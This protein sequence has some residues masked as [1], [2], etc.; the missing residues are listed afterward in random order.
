[1]K[2]LNQQQFQNSS[3]RSYQIVPN[4]IKFSPEIQVYGKKLHC[5]IRSSLALTVFFETLFT[6]GLIL[7]KQNVRED[8]KAVLKGKRFVAVK[9][10]KKK[11]ITEK[12]IANKEIIS[13]KA[14][15]I[16]KT[17]KKIFL[18]EKKHE[19]VAVKIKRETEEK[20]KP[21]EKP[22]AHNKEIEEKEKQI[23]IL[24]P[25]EKFENFIEILNSWNA[26]VEKTKQ[27]IH[28]LLLKKN[29]EEMRIELEKFD[30]SNQNIL[31]LIEKNMRFLT[32]DK[33]KEKEEL[34]PVLEECIQNI[35][36]ADKWIDSLKDKIVAFEKATAVFTYP[37]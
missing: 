18:E 11:I 13:N 20:K 16:E 3:F 35:I 21:E 7:F 29:L 34:K 5:R 15:K 31:A 14:G 12:K 25:E 28:C 33:K 36:N 10:E 22:K 4:P 6:L 27:F 19:K 8:W 26:S 37:L 30:R 17:S 2:I 1:M 32:D 24:S 23:E 9:I